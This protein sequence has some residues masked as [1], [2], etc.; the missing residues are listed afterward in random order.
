MEIV[1]RGILSG[2]RSFLIVM[3]NESL[4]DPEQILAPRRVNFAHP[5]DVQSG[6]NKKS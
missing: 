6:V 3:S 4:K 2:K 1:E 5:Q